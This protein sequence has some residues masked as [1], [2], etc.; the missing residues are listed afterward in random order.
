MTEAPPP[1]GSSKLTATPGINWAAGLVAA[2]VLGHI[3]GL[4]VVG[5]TNEWVQWIVLGFVALLAAGGVGFAVRLTSPVGA[6]AF[7]PAA[8]TGGLAGHAIIALA[9]NGFD[10]LGYS[11]LGVY[12]YGPLSGYAIFVGVLA[13]IVATVARKK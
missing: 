4:I 9:G 5:I 12:Q 8:I 1:P 6:A 2:I 13:G 7:L 10:E 3:L 11:L